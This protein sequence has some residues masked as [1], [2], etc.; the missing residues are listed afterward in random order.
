MYS[1]FSAGILN[2]LLNLLLVIVFHL[3]VAGVAIATVISNALSA[4]L[5]LWFLMTEEPLFRFKLQSL[6]LDKTSLSSIL[7]VGVPAGIQSMVF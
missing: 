4:A 7:M 5:V 6:C 2:V 1:L 3:G